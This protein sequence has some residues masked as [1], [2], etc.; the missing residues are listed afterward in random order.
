MSNIWVIS[1]VSVFLISLLSF[2]GLLFLAFKKEILQKLLLFLV[3]FA[4]GGLLGGA[5]LHLL[6]EAI[7]QLGNGSSLALAVLLG[8]LGFF[9]LEK[10][11]FWRHC[12]IP[13]SKTHP[14]PVVFMNL[15][16]DGFHNL[17]DGV[18]IAASFM[19]NFSL[20]IATTL[21][22]LIHEIPQEIG[23]F[24]VLLYGGFS[25]VK[26]LL[27]NFASALVAILGAILTLALGAKF[28]NLVPL[29]IPFTAGGFIY[30]ASSDLIPE[31]H[32]ETQ[33]GKSLLQFL[34]LLL[35]ITLMFLL[36]LNE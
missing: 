31:L 18:M 22:V 7:G 34:G 5:F 1:L 26:A 9:V 13:T 16:G 32:K 30:I 27:F 15:V 24:S 20:G 14:H 23:D 25:K 36:T 11:I 29:L 10:F 4:T 8:I 33:I 17:L 12:H 2:V 35:G 6:P 3:S 28:V 21:A 19:T